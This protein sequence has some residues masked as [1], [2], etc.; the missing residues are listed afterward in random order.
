MFDRDM[1]YLV[2]SRRW[3]RDY[4]LL[5]RDLTGLSHYDVFPE[6][7]ERW[8]AV[9]R[10]ALAGQVLQSDEDAFPRPDGR[11]QWLRWE[12]R[13][14]RDAD[15]QIAGIVIFSED[16]TERHEA[17]ES[18]RESE[19]R[20]RQLAD[21]MPQ[22]V[23][24]AEPD[25]TVDYYNRRVADFV[26][27]ERD[28]DG[29]WRWQGALHPDDQAPTAHAWLTAVATGE[30]YQCEHRVRLADGGTRWFLSRGVPVRDRS[31]R[32]VKWFG[33]ATDIHDLKRA[34]AA[35][36]E[37]DRRKDEFIATL[38]HEL[39]NPLAPIRNAVEVLKQVETDEPRARWARELI[40]R[41]VH[42]M[43]HLIDDLLDVGRI[44]RG[45]LHLRKERVALAG[46]LEQALDAIRAD[47]VRAEQS[48]EVSMP[49]VPAI[50]SADPVRLAQVVSNLLNNASKYSGPGSHIQVR[51]RLDGPEVVM[52]VLDEGIGLAPEDLANVFDMFYKVHSETGCTQTGLGIG[53]SLVK[54]LVE[55][56]GGSVEARS[57]GVGKGSEFVVRLPLDPAACMRTPQDPP[58]EQGRGESAHRVLVVDDK[59][60]VVESMAM[61]LRLHGNAVETASDG[62]EAV[63]AA[64]RF[65]PELI[66]LD[67]G[68]PRLDGLDACRRIRAQPWGRTMKIVAV[69]GRGQDE[70]RR[71]TAEAGFDGHLVKP[72]APAAVLALLGDKH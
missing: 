14:W 49:D 5:G 42:H 58:P 32:M 59:A 7:P 6:I 44:T 35:L 28:A 29:S 31:G 34:Q 65:R 3:L 15:G 60:D 11:L 54:G 23:W 10:R 47:I 69:T 4:G 33:T 70:D 36:Q 62:I 38:G 22:L 13:P 1:R 39:R 41:Q 8:R 63:A 20:F 57:E 9:H 50:L 53:L 30:P 19:E 56:H 66:L 55:M 26:G 21:S 48:L 27:I 12:V 52:G 24:T 45:R 2:A 37:A 46:V 18:L 72:V 51:V 43:T 16:I 64:E 61:L 71:R 25:G 40:D 68:M 17:E 67:L